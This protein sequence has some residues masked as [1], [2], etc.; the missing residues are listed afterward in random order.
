MAEQN[1]EFKV[2]GKEL[3]K[4]VKD[5]LHEGNIRKITIKDKEGNV[6]L[7]IPLTLGVIGA[8]IAPILAAVGAVAALLTECTISVERKEK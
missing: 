2:S 8:V 5:L 6:I 1:E 3:Q 7:A 4:K